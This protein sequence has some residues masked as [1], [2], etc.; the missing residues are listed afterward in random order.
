VLTETEMKAKL[1]RV[2]ADAHLWRTESYE[3]AHTIVAQR[4][5][6]A[7]LEAELEFAKAQLRLAAM[8][9]SGR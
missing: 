5:R 1:E 9:G 8:P 3:S 6:I 7:R 2:E 4:K